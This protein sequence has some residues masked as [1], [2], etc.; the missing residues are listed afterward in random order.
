MVRP[1]IMLKSNASVEQI[2]LNFS[3]FLLLPK[4]HEHLLG[5]LLKMLKGEEIE[6]VIYSVNIFSVFYIDTIYYCLINKPVI[7]NS[8]NE[9]YFL[10]LVGQRRHLF[11]FK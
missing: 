9:N 11:R 3:P 4:R 8:F 1:S 6:E 10:V 5:D 2:V 7:Y